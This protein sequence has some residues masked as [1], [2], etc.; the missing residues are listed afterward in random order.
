MTSAFLL[1][2]LLVQF[3]VPHNSFVQTTVCKPPVASANHPSHTLDRNI[4][5]MAVANDAAA[6]ANRETRRANANDRIVELRK[7]MGMTLDEV[8]IHTLLPVS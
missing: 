3:I 7:P 6:R 1:V 8:S 2:L 4:R 5:Y